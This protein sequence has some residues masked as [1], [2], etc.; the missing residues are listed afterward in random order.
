MWFCML[1]GG[2]WIVFQNFLSFRGP[3]G[4]NFTH[5]LYYSSIIHKNRHFYEK[6]FFVGGLTKKIKKFFLPIFR[7]WF[8][9]GHWVYNQMNFITIEGL[10]SAFQNG[11]TLENPMKIERFI[12]KRLRSGIFAQILAKT[13]G[14]Y[15]GH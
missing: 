10:V 15:L 5:F 1:L 4:P 13:S 8:L 6:N 14:G 9:I 2:F 12:A 3:R 11:M 7:S